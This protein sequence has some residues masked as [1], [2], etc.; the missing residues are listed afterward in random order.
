MP[1]ARTTPRPRPHTRSCTPN[2]DAC[3]G[4]TPCCSKTAVCDA[5]SQTCEEP[6]CIPQLAA[7]DWNPWT[8]QPIGLPCCAGSVCSRFGPGVR[9]CLPITPARTRPA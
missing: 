9:V 1:P 5:T 6:T 2:G 3:D 7:C 4:V 8:Q